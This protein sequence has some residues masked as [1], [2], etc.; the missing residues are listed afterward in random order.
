MQST[1]EGRAAAAPSV[2]HRST[3]PPACG[4]GTTDL[5]YAIAAASTGR[6]CGG[7]KVKA[8]AT[9]PRPIAQEAM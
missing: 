5:R 8:I 2:P 9:A 6:G 3:P 1:V 4:G 7:R